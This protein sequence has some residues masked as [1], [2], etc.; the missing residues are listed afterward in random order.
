LLNLAAQE[1]IMASSSALPASGKIYGI[2]LTDRKSA[3]F[4]DREILKPHLGDTDQSSDGSDDR[5]DASKST[6]V[7]RHNMERMGKQF[8]LLELAIC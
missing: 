4:E 2:E 1:F 7:D 6:N 8:T 3:Q 5:V